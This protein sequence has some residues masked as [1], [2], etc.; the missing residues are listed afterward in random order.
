MKSRTKAYTTPQHKVMQLENKIDR[1]GAPKLSKPP[2]SK[3]S[4]SGKVVRG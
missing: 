2:I 4:M 3:G 1:K